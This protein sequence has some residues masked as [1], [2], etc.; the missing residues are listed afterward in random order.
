MDL[1]ETGWVGT[2]WINLAEDIER[3]RFPMRSLD[4]LI[5]LTF[6]AALWAWVRLSL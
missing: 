5:D 3:I 6:P 1:R 4:F 2:D